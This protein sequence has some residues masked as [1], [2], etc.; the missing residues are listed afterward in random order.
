LGF[1][2]ISAVNSRDY[3]LMMGCFILITTAVV[4]ANLIVDLV[5]PVIDPRILKPVSRKRRAGSKPLTSPAEPDAAVAT[6]V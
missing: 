6:K 5:Y 2:L 1:K 4:I 3:S